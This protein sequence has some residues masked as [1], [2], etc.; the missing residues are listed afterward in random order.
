M[1]C[2]SS[3]GSKRHAKVVHTTM[4]VTDGIFVASETGPED[5]ARLP[6]DREGIQGN[7]AHRQYAGTPWRESYGFLVQERC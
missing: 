1:H 2:L 7:D 5:L 6:A 4:P 3:H